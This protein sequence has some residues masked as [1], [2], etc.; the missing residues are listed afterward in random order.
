MLVI[1]SDDI[2]TSDMGVGL[3][4]DIHTNHLGSELRIV[5]HLLCGDDARLQDV[6]LVV[7]IV[8]KHV[9]GRN[10]LNQPLFKLLPL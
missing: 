1:G 8:Q 6:L 10:A 4:G 2:N 5:E 9:Q 7:D 3:H